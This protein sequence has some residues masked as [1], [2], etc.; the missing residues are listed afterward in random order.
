MHR[1]GTSAVAGSL[2]HAGVDF[3]PRLMPAT[4]ANE[5]GYYEHVDVVNLHDR[6]LV[7]LD[8][9]W[10]SVTPWPPGWWE[11][12]DR[13]VRFR[14]ELLTLLKRD[15]AGSALWGV[16]DPRL[17]RLLPWWRPLWDALET[18]PVFLFVVRDPREV[19]VS[20]G[21]R[22]GISPTKSYVLWHQHLV[23]AEKATRGCKRFF[24]NFDAFMEDWAL[25]LSPLA[26]FL[27]P[28]WESRLASA[29]EANAQFLDASLRRASAAAEQLGPIP[30]WL[31]GIS[32]LLSRASGQDEEALASAIDVLADGQNLAAVLASQRESERL[33]DLA[34]EL[35]ASRKLARWYEAEWQK[36]ARRAANQKS[37]PRAPLAASN[38][39]LVSHISNANAIS[40]KRIQIFSIVRKWGVF[41]AQFFS[42]FFR[43]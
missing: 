18:E 1:S 3:G 41:L 10:D 24:L 28:F 32:L 5:R 2:Q 34:I 16:K 36:A 15:F 17:C 27:G 35:S 39:P 19:A 9:G 12:E 4:A 37:P 31:E 13:T 14:A 30:S 42:R 29:R 7:A 21:R 38:Q 26:R 23:E 20:L 40:N 33:S 25:A 11:D 22:E 6:L 43:F 8:R